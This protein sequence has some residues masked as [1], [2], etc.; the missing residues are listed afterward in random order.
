M[1]ILTEKPPVY[2]KVAAVFGEDAI[3]KAVFAYGDTIYNLS[4]NPIPDDLLVHE[5]THRRQQEAFGGPDAWWDEYLSSA[6]FRRSQEME[7]YGEQYKS[8][9]DFCP[10]RN[11][12][13]RFLHKLASDFSGLMY[14]NII[15]YTDA[16]NGI[17]RYANKK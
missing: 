4:G 1:R 14:G 15:N 11:M 9:C 6:S 12:R 13:F 17:M 16:K 8:F 10:D 7:A 5:S 3:C 2:Q